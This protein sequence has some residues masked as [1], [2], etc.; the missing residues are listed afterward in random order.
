[1][2]FNPGEGNES[3]RVPGPGGVSTHFL[4]NRS[5]AA[6]CVVKHVQPIAQPPG[7]RTGRGRSR[8]ALRREVP[9]PRCCWQENPADQ[10]AR[11]AVLSALGATW[12]ME[13]TQSRPSA[14]ATRSEKRLKCLSLEMTPV[15]NAV[16]AGSSST[17]SKT[18]DSSPLNPVKRSSPCSPSTQFLSFSF[19]TV[20]LVT[21]A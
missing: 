6:P 20:S 14:G 19:Y 11:A 18:M 2:V 16:A 3:P 17:F 10:E 13:F 12:R 8:C 9:V 1:M 21:R 4:Q 15:A 7:Q 5:Y